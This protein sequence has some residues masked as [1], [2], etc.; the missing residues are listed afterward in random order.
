MTIT[1]KSVVNCDILGLAKEIQGN[2]FC[3]AFFKAYLYL[4]ADVKVYKGLKYVSIKIA[5]FNLQKCITWTKKSSKGR[6]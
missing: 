6:Q 4:L 1:L 3:H 2:Y 5:Q